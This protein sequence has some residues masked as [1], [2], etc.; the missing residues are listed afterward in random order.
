MFKFWVLLKIVAQGNNNSRRLASPVDLSRDHYLGNAEAEIQLVE[1]GSYSCKHCHAAHEVIADLRDRFGDR[2]MYVFRQL[3]IRGSETAKSTF[4][5]D[6]S[7]E[8]AS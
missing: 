6:L 4:V 8:S 2:V 1:Y 7:L 3:P 5:G